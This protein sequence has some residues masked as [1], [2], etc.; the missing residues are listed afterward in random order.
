M[1]EHDHDN[2][3]EHG[4]EQEQGH[5]LEVERISDHE[6][7]IMIDN[8]GKKWR[9]LILSISSKQASEYF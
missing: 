1:F 7:S 2:E 3:L 9:L 4:H 6:D 5:E 8:D